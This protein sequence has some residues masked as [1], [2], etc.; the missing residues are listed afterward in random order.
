MKTSD[1]MKEQLKKDFAKILGDS[2]GFV[3]SQSDKFIDDIVAIVLTKIEE[4]KK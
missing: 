3:R 4:N 2:Y 1:E